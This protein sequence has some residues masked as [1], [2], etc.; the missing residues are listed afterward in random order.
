MYTI[1]NLMFSFLV[2]YTVDKI[3]W[4]ITKERN[5]KLEMEKI[6]V[7]VA[8]IKNKEEFYKFKNKQINGKNAFK[9]YCEDLLKT[10]G[11]SDLKEIDLFDDDTDSLVGFKDDEKYYI[12][13]KMWDWET[14]NE[15]VKRKEIQMLVG[16]MVK[17][18]IDNG[19]IITTS[20]FSAEAFSYAKDIPGINLELI[21]GDKLVKLI[22]NLRE[23]WL[24]ELSS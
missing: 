8:K 21:D 4:I 6:K 13:C 11:F 16:A 10:I 1:I 2:I 15:K 22:S 17:D 7:E 3:Y 20:H 9:V 18:S 14:K 19:I 24:T 23:E 5:N 12:E